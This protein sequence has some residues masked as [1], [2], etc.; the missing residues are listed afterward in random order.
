M[1]KFR[2]VGSGSHCFPKGTIVTLEND[3]GTKVKLYSN[4]ETRQW[5]HDSNVQKV[6]EFQSGDIVK[7]KNPCSMLVA[8]KEYQLSHIGG[9]DLMAGKNE[10][11]YGSGCSC[12]DN[13]I[14]V[15]GANSITLNNDNVESV[16]GSV[17]SSLKNKPKLKIMSKVKEYVKNLTLSADEKALREVGFKDENGAFTSEAF[18]VIEEK[19]ANDNIAYL[20]EIAK[21]IISEEKK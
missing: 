16:I 4:G 14:L 20:V 7:L 19:L 1:S 6:A 18:D 13:W 21:G 10:E 3:D 12:V 8:N 9:G 2:V 15:E 11:C 17:C 5:I